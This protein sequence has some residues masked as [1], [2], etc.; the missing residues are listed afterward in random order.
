M[1]PYYEHA[2]ITIYHGDCRELL[3]VIGGDAVL[4]ATDPPY[5]GA[6]DED[7]DNQW[8]DDVAFVSWLGEV[9]LLL[10]EATTDNATIY[11]FASPRLAAQ[12]EVKIGS[13]YRVISSAVWDKGDG[14]KGAAGSGIDVTALRAYW[15]ANT[16]RVIIAE[17]RSNGE[18]LRADDAAKTA[19][20]YWS[21]C[22]EAKRSVIGDY[23]KTEFARAG[24]TNKEVAALFPSKTG[25][26]TGCVSNWILG[27][28][29]QLRCSTKQ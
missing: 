27:P 7:W 18:F 1:K 3:P 10:D 26:L 16:E 12:V 22:E 5:C 8:A 14:R 20:G 15:P 17:K 11:A 21:K 9:L 24:V 25:G 19:C 29:F 28:T 13:L 4:V 2:G 6:I 23:L